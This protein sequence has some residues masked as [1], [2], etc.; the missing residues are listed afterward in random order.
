MT[1]KSSRFLEPMKDMFWGI[2]WLLT[3]A[4]VI[5]MTL[6]VANA[7]G[8]TVRERTREVAVLKVL[9]FGRRR[10]LFLVLGEGLR[11]AVA[12]AAI[13]L[14]A[15]AAIARLLQGL[16]SGA[17]DPDPRVFAAAGAMMLIVAGVAAL[18]PARRASA[19]DPIVVLRME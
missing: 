1:V 10:I 6:I 9:G 11:L 16:L 19:V 5:V 7:I 12:G 15:A 18:V 3:P 8:I 13:G 2:K 4:I 14:V 17:A